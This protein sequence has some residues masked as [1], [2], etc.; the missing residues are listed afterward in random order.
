MSDQSNYPECLSDEAKIIYA[1]AFQPNKMS[2][3]DDGRVIGRQEGFKAC[4]TRAVNH[5]EPIIKRLEEEN[6]NLKR[7][8]NLNYGGGF[9]EETIMIV[10][11]RKENESLKEQIEQMRKQLKYWK[12]NSNLEP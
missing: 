3:F 4:R 2:D 6:E 7:K 5:Y 1:K 9:S 12:E 10:A 8:L 11:L